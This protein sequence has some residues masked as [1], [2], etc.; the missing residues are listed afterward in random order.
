VYTVTSDSLLAGLEDPANET[1]WRGYVERYRPML[2][3]WFCRVGLAAADADDVAQ[4]VL[5]A[6]ANAYREGKY[7]RERGRLR[8]WLFGIARTML[9]GFHRRQ[10]RKVRV[11]DLDDDGRSA[12]DDVAAPDE[13]TAAWEQEW[14]DAVL[15]QCLE[16]VQR[17]VTPQTYQAFELFA[18]GG[19][20]ARDVAARL[21]MSENAVFGAKHRVLARIRE[22]QPE[23]ERIW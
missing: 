15:R 12:L 10:S 18:R 23:I 5:I 13:L 20:A 17:E 6:F 11:A 9:R 7:D 4:D 19:L 21:G 1:V 14:R 3:R 22:L 2:V 16:E 8:A